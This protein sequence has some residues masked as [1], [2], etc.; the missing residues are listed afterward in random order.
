[1]AIFVGEV[2]GLK[3]LNTA[4]KA[5][6]QLCRKVDKNSCPCIRQSSGGKIGEKDM[7]QLA[8]EESK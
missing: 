2:R 6:A 3:N 1:M 8:I 7:L 5:V 4:R